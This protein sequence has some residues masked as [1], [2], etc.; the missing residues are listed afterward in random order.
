MPGEKPIPQPTL[1]ED[2]YPT[3]SETAKYVAGQRVFFE[4]KPYQ[5]KWVNEGESPASA[6]TNSEGSAWA[7]LTQAQIKLE[8][9]KLKEK[10]K[11]GK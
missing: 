3:W 1:P 8:L 5:A 2:T 6:L 7:P 11:G 10:A 9:S 4:G